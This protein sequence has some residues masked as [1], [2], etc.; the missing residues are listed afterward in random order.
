MTDS[1]LK[2]GTLIFFVITTLLI[3]FLLEKAWLASLI[4]G[5]LTALFWWAMMYLSYAWERKRANKKA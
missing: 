1:R 5:L 3:H 2:I 4:Q